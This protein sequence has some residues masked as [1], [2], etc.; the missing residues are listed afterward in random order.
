MTS[1]QVLNGLVAHSINHYKC[2][3]KLLHSKIFKDGYN[4]R[5]TDVTGKNTVDSYKHQKKNRKYIK[6]IK[7]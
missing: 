6:I 1:Q 4:N 5:S 3:G 7:A 2:L